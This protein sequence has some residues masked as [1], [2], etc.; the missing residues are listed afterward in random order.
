MGEE[1]AVE[2]GAAS[3][4]QVLLCL[5]AELWDTVDALFCPLDINFCSNQQRDCVFGTGDGGR[6]GLEDTPGGSHHVSS[7]A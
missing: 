6:G 5:D 3:A 2:E 4:A 1:S 7:P